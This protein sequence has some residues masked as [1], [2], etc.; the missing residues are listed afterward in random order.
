MP[1]LGNPTA[2]VLYPG[3]LIYAVL[4]YAWG[5]RVY[6]V[7]HTILAFVAMLVLMRSWQVSWTGSGLGALAYTFGVPILFQS[8]NVIFLVGA[9]WLPLGFHAVD[10]WV[11]LGRRWGILELAVVLS[12]QTL[13]GDPQVAY[14]LGLAALG[15]AAGLAWHRGA[16][17]QS[18]TAPGSDSR[19]ARSFGW[20]W[21]LIV[22]RSASWCW[23]VVTLIMAQ[24]LPTL[25]PKT[26]QPPTP[27]ALPWMRYVPPA[28]SCRLDGSRPGFPRLLAT[29]RLA[30]PARD[31]LRWDWP[32]RRRWPWRFR[33]RSSFR[34]SSSPSRRRERPSRG[35]M[36]SI[37]SASSHCGCPGCSGPMRWGFSSKATRSGA[38]CSGCRAPCPKTWVPSLYMGCLILV[39]GTGALS[40]R[41]GTPWRVWLSVIFVVSLVLSLGQYTSPIWAT[42]V[43]AKL[44]NLRGA[45]RPRPGDR[46]A[47]SGRRA[48]RSASTGS[49]G[50]AMAAST[51]WF[52]RSCRDSAS[53]ASPPSFSR[54][55]AWPWPPSPDW[56]G[57]AF[58]RA[59]RAGSPRSRPHCWC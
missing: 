21:L 47:R 33:R 22:A 49:C 45:S 52:R 12:M 46:P 36:T 59:V 55:A 9:A 41:R 40:F 56:D 17:S 31:R 14:L 6:I 58:V 53:F 2:A 37:P 4:P 29:S 54:S 39:L 51:G 18:P 44:T 26:P 35:L 3:K 24:W 10:R 42:R 13:G 50:M 57:T 32:G 5:A 8:C 1:L 48:R 27:M 20:L 23:V 30:V 34:S 15:Y 25:R 38:T 7:A 11:R 16:S 43:L 28:V 19:S